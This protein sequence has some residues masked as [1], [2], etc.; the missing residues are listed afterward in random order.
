MHSLRYKEGDPNEMKLKKAYLL[1]L[2][3]AMMLL[4]GG[5]KTTKNNWFYRWYHN[6]NARYNGYFYSNLNMQESIKKVEK[7]YKEDYTKLLPIYIL[8][9]NKTSKTY[10]ADFDK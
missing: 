1:L 8:T 4:L 7:A 5:C 6:S 9:D 3:P 10:Y 2:L